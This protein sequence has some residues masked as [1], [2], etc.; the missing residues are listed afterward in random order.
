MSIERVERKDGSVVW[1]VRWRQAGQNRSKVLG[2]KRD[3][4]AFDAELRRKR[5]TGEL[6]AL[7]A[8]KET[9]AEFG[10]EW[11]TLYAESNLAATTLEVYAILW[12]THV[13]P[14]LGSLRLREIT[15]SIITRFRLELEADGVGRV[16]IPTRTHT[17]SRSSIRPSGSM[18]P[19]AFATPARSCAGGRDSRPSSMWHDCRRRRAAR[20]VRGGPPLQRRRPPARPARRD[21]P[22]G[23]PA[24]RLRDRARRLALQVPGRADG[25]QL[26]WDGGSLGPAQRRLQK[27]F[28]AGLLERFGPVSLRGSYP[29]TYHLG[30]RG[31]VIL[32]DS[33][34]V[35]TGWRYRPHVV[36][37]FGH[38]LH[39]LQLNAWVL[40]YHRQPGVR[41]LSWEG[42]RT[43]EPPPT[44]REE[45]E[46][47]RYLPGGG[48]TVD[49]LRDPRHRPV[50]PDA[51]IELDR[52]DARTKTSATS[53]CTP[54]TTSSPATTTASTTTAIGSS[55]AT[56]SSSPSSRTCTPAASTPGACRR[57]PGT[58]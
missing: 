56:G 49:R 54:P 30:E 55:A 42:E 14:R 33:Q 51:V 11:W 48:W 25:A 1:R 17:S 34:V 24:A 6:A 44:T 40:A 4:E 26:H 37:E 16:S 46:E 8:G 3:A 7:D 45:R 21:R 58:I 15:P 57:S 20:V 31:H 50:R 10:E 29:W 28:N 43:F 36:L 12:D 27:M 32:R 39:E 38:V 5:R 53:S 13:L 47:P 19:S 23:D 52:G 41:F 35:E 9:L 18:P 2:R 22:D